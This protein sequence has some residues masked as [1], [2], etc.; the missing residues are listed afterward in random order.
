MIAGARSEGVPELG[1]GTGA[2]GRGY[3]HGSFASDESLVAAL[4]L[5]RPHFT[6]RGQ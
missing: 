6:L 3:A 2:D 1:V 5:P 4:S